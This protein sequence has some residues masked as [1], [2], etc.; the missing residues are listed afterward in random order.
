[1]YS[2]VTYV[3]NVLYCF[4]LSPLYTCT[5]QIVLYSALVYLYCSNCTVLPPS[6]PVLLKLYCT[7]TCTA[8]IVL[9]CP[10][11]YLYC[12]NCTVLSPSTWFLFSRTSC[13]NIHTVRTRKLWNK[14][15]TLWQ[16]LFEVFTKK[17]KF[18]PDSK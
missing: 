15:T 9:Y 11:V 6:K 14:K 12:S 13:V 4:V 7:A 10:L 8:Q 3:I 1:M 16:Y 17:N 18:Y 2:I 5:A